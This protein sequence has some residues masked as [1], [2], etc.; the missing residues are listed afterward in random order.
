M[1]ISLWTGRV[2]SPGY[3]PVV[4]QL[5]ERGFLAIKV[6]AQWLVSLPERVNLTE[7]EMMDTFK[8]MEKTN[9][10]FIDQFSRRRLTSK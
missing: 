8:L 4:Q 10:D 6:P 5:I 9:T 3:F 7:S 1:I 2:R